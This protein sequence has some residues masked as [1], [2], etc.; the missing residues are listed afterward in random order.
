MTS[1]D[2]SYCKHE[3]NLKNTRTNSIAR[4]EEKWC[5]TF[6]EWQMLS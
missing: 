6:D 5:I 1:I 4:T 3:L 2:S